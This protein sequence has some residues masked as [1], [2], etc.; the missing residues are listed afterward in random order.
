M[1]ACH[2]LMSRILPAMFS[3]TQGDRKCPSALPGGKAQ[4]WRLHLQSYHPELKCKTAWQRNLPLFTRGAMAPGRT[5]SGSTHTLHEDFLEEIN[6]RVLQKVQ[7]PPPKL[8]R[9]GSSLFPRNVGLLNWLSFGGFVIIPPKK[10]DSWLSLC[11][12]KLWYC[13]ST[14][15]IILQG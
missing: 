6:I 10:W 3:V 11:P 13:T 7:N 12:D 1:D 9:F 4:R 8:L 5:P 14:V 2:A 15:F